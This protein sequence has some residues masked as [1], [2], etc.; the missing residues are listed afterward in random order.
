MNARKLNFNG[1]S[2]K[3]VYAR[4]LAAWVQGTTGPTNRH[5][6]RMY[7]AMQRML[8]RF[9]AREIDASDKVWVWSDLH[10]GHENI[11]RYTNRP[12]ADADVMDAALYANWEKTVGEDDTLLIVGDLAM[13]R[14]ISKETWQK[15]R[16]GAGRI[17]HLV[18]GNHDLTGA[19]ELRVSGFNLVSSL[20]CVAGDPPIV[21]THLPLDS[22]PS[23]WVN[24]HGHTHADP[25]RRSPHI[26][27]SVEQLDYVPV[28]LG[29]LQ[30]LARELVDGRYPEGSTTIERLARIGA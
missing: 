22:V 23:G 3:A 28:A 24:V 11:I 20:V 16:H 9:P 5:N 26:N 2:A 12:F 19:G 8:G 15:V 7:R 14:A 17:K 27:V 4:D 6:R 1:E 29:R 25:P 30:A 18:L 13:R 21:C 10:L